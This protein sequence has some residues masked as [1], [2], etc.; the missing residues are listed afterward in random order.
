M[1]EGTLPPCL[2]LPPKHLLGLFL[3]VRLSL[4]IPIWSQSTMRSAGAM[5]GFAGSESSTGNFQACSWPAQEDLQPNP[6][7]GYPKFSASMPSLLCCGH[8]ATTVPW[9]ET[10]NLIHINH[11]IL[12]TCTTFKCLKPGETSGMTVNFTTLWPFKDLIVL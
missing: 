7:T 1:S 12:T 8:L 5:Q 4:F 3:A 11:Q 2:P 6:D 10:A 9:T